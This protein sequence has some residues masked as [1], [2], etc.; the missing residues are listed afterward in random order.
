MMNFIY[1]TVVEYT[2]NSCM[3]RQLLSDSLSIKKRGDRYVRE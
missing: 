2:D 3:K 1:E